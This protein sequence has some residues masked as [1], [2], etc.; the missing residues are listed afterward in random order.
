MPEWTNEQLKAIDSRDGTVLVS[1]AAG[2]GKTAVLVE[3]VIRRLMNKEKPCSADRLLIVT[4]TR[5]ATQQM[6]DRIFQAISEKLKEN[7]DDA[8]LKRQLIMLPFAKISTIDSFCADIV[9]ENF[10]SLDISPDYKMLEGAQLKLVEADALSRVLDE[11]YKENSGE[12]NEIINILANGTDDSA[13]G[14]LI[15]RLY[16]NSIAFARPEIWLDSLIDEY[17]CDLPLAQSKWGGIIMEQAKGAVEFCRHITRKMQVCLDEDETVRER[18]SENVKEITLSLDELDTVICGGDW[19]AVREKLSKFSLS[20]LGRLPKNYSS[21]EAEFIKDQKKN[22]TKQ[23]KEKLLPLFCASEEENREDMTYLRPLAEKMTSAVRRYGEILSEEKQK[24]NSVDF[25]DISHL[26]LNLLVFYN[27]NGEPVKTELADTI[28]EKFDEILVDEFQDINEL[29]STLFWAV[30]KNDTN[31]FTVGDV[32]QSI[33]RFRQAM[34]EIFLRRR[35]KMKDYVDGNYPAKIILDRN[36]RSRSGVTENINFVFRQLMSEK[37]GGLNYDRNE[38]LVAAA[39][40]EACSFIQTELHIIGDLDGEKVNRTI[41]A[42][43]V[44]EIINEAI[45]NKMQVADKNGT[46]DIKFSDFCILMRATGGGRAE[47]YSEVLSRNGILSYVSDKSGFFEASEISSMLN[48][49]RVVDNPVQDIPLLAVLLSPF[50]GFTADELAK[51]RIDE[52]DKPLYHCLLKSAE[53]GYE[54]SAAFLDSLENLRMLASTLSCSDFVRELYNF[55]GCKAIANAMKNGSQRNVNLNLFVDYAAKYEESGKRGLSGFIRF[56]DRVQQQNGN[57]E[58]ASDI[59]EAANVVRIMTIHKSKGLEFPV[60]ILADLNSK[61]TNDNQTNIATFHPDYGICFERR[62]GRTKCQYPTVGRKALVTAERISSVSEELRV[63]YVA[64]TRAKEQLICVTRYDNIQNKLK[65]LALMLNGKE[66]VSPFSVLNAGCMADWLVTAFMRHPDAEIL[67]KLSGDSRIQTLDAKER[68]IVK[69]INYVDEA[70]NA[71]EEETEEYEADE[72]LLCEIRERIDYKYPYASLA[73]VRA[74]SAPSDF[75]KTEFDTEYFAASKPQFLSKSGLNPAARGTATHKFMEF[76]DY[77]AQKYDVHSQTVRMV[78]EN[79]LTENEA[80]AL[81][82]DKLE[83]FFSGEIAARIRVSPLLMREKK[84]T[85]GIKAGELYPDLPENVRDETV[86][87]QG[88]VDCAFEEDGKL[89]IVDYKT[90]RNVTMEELRERY[91]SQLK[92]YELALSQ[93]TGREI[94]GT[95]IYSFDN[96][97]YIEL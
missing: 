50:F 72:N 77:T 24:I 31:M 17:R 88:Y 67:R 82:T 51:M 11:L 78:E 22:I 42:Q 56:I 30:S 43:H 39:P 44:A 60:C 18:Y 41:E 25:S 10:H 59:S 21:P 53:S 68:L 75:E 36:F 93:C 64:M 4:F 8:H 20:N 46:R 47:L 71:E 81:E 14:G 74:K 84:V 65:E 49:M 52:R 16:N 19:N 5:A 96:G 90:D 83:K 94:A 85:V 37:A 61:F 35:D 2:S 76:F 6:R 63:L 70:E 15:Q 62:D 57:L 33:Y 45:K 1:A 73:P 48:L 29:Q 80:A 55:T 9:R 3:R 79:H 28:S 69:I 66:P 58:S 40:Y 87:I 54:K 91:R 12:F 23:I 27:E 7:P 86:V 13:V 95:L 97:T 89:V 32:K 26:A 34:P 38:E 92:M